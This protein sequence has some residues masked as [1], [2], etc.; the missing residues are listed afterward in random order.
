[1][2]VMG[3]SPFG[4]NWREE[5][6]DARAIGDRSRDFGRSGEPEWGA[7]GTGLEVL[8]TRP[9]RCRSSVASG[10]EFGPATGK[11]APLEGS[12]RSRRPRDISKN[13]NN[14]RQASGRPNCMYNSTGSRYEETASKGRG[15]VARETPLFRRYVYDPIDDFSHSDDDRRFQRRLCTRGGA[16]AGG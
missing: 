1:M 15:S 2:A 11:P 7:A 5:D 8:E 12:G 6:S 10:L 14:P 16:G 9:S 3:R 13:R 4:S